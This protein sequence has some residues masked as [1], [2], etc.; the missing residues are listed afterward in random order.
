M[1]NRPLTPEQLDDVMKNGTVV[2]TF[3]EKVNATKWPNKED[4]VRLA[5]AVRAKA[6]VVLFKNGTRFDI[7][8]KTAYR[9]PAVFVSPSITDSF[10][11]C[12]YFSVRKLEEFLSEV[13]LGV[14][15]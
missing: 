9:E 11:P 7:R 8:Y 5:N 2:Q 15:E 14:A 6:P 3:E 4:K 12:G 10:I 1:T 13:N